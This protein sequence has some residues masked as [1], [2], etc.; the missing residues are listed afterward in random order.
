MERSKIEHEDGS[1]TLLVAGPAGAVSL[2]TYVH[3]GRLFGVLGLHQVPSEEEFASGDC[4]ECDCLPGGIC[5]PDSG[6][7]VGQ[8]LAPLALSDEEAAYA[9]L[10]SWYRERIEEER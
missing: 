10:E 1:V 9:E 5:R 6:Y 7:R 8:D 2:N 3:K 4:M